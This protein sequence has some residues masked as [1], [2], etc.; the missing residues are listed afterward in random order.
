LS[1]KS[2]KGLYFNKSVPK[3]STN[4]S[5]GKIVFTSGGGIELNGPKSNRKISRK[6]LQ[7]A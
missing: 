3:T 7:T 6:G 1:G 5:L 4:A 2:N